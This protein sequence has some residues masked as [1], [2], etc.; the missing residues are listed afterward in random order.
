M[1]SVF[2]HNSHPWYIL[3]SSNVR[4]SHTHMRIHMCTMCVQPPSWFSRPGT[5]VTRETHMAPRTQHVLRSCAA[6]HN[7]GS[8]LEAVTINIGCLLFVIN[9]TCMCSVFYNLVV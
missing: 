9:C 4:N 6:P 2:V 1:F 8:C 7:A 3:P 5:Y